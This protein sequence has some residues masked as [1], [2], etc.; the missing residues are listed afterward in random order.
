MLSPEAH[1]RPSIAEV[2]ATIAEYLEQQRRLQ[3]IAARNAAKK[4]FDLKMR[5][6]DQRQGQHDIKKVKFSSKNIH[7]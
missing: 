7:K 4:V 2:C 6:S 1:L 5:S 3:I